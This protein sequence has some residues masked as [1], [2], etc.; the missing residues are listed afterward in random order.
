M[1]RA[2]SN[3]DQFITDGLGSQQAVILCEC[4][5]LGRQSAQLLSRRQA[6]RA[7]PGEGAP[8]AG[9]AG[10][11]PVAGALHNGEYD[12]TLAKFAS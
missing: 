7:R 8:F 1:V 11:A 12:D 4:R 5:T 6:Q 10:G 9:R 3:H 2:D